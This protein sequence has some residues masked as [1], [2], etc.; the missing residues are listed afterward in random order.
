MVLKSSTLPLL[1]K[2]HVIICFLHKYTRILYC[3]Y[4]KNDFSCLYKSAFIANHCRNYG[5]DAKVRRG[6]DLKAA[7]VSSKLRMRFYSS[8]AALYLVLHVI[9]NLTLLQILRFYFRFYYSSCF[10]TFFKFVFFC[11]HSEH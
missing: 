2:Q 8:S 5:T 9:S 1:H 6:D 10:M 4:F 11:D 3:T 7:Y